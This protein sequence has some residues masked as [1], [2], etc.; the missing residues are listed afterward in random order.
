MKESA[1]RRG[2]GG[3][4]LEKGKLNRVGSRRGQSGSDIEVPK[5][6]MWVGALQDEDEEANRESER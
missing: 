4:W 5:A 1:S 2:S 3:R 6:D